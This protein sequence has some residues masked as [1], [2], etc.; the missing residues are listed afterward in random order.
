MLSL[1]HV[2]V[3]AG[4]NGPAEE[5][6]RVTQKTKLSFTWH[7][8]AEG[9]HETCDVQLLCRDAKRRGVHLP[10]AWKSGWHM[11]ADVLPVD[12]WAR[13]AVR[14][15]W[16]DFSLPP[17]TKLDCRQF[18]TTHTCTHARTHLLTCMIVGMLA[19]VHRR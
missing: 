19:T 8:M 5:C 10:Q 1:L 7:L 17:A 2:H 4:Y 13:D 18:Q 16:D 11:G 3:V 14:R 15:V 12:A 9:L 6:H